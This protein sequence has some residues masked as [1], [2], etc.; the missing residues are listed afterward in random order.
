MYSMKLEWKEFNVNLQMFETWMKAASDL[1]V[2]N[3]ADTAL[4][5]WFSEEP[6]EEVKD[7]VEIKWDEIDEMS[8]EAETYVSAQDVLDAQVAKKA[9]GKAKLLALGLTQDEVDALLG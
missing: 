4:T 5:L 6:S 3:S 8:E 7:A 2:G 1:Y 9:S